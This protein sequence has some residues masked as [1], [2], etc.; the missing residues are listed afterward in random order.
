MIDKLLGEGGFGAVYK[1]KDSKTGNFYAMKVEKKQEKK[2][3]KL[4]M[5]VI[6][7]FSS[8]TKLVLPLC[9]L[10]FYQQIVN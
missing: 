3:S 5:E 2:P 10:W 8:W 9:Y 4:K 1:V 7:I 6:T